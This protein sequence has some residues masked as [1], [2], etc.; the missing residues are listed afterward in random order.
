MT[1]S[2]NFGALFFFI[3]SILFIGHNARSETDVLDFIPA[4]IASANRPTANYQF[5][6]TPQGDAVVITLTGEDPLDGTLTFEVVSDPPNGDLTGTPPNLTYS[7]DT[8]FTGKDS[9]SFTVTNRMGTSKAA[10]VDIYVIDPANFLKN[11]MVD[12]AP[13][14]SQ[15]DHAGAFYFRPNYEKVF[16]EFG[17][18]VLEDHQGQ[19]KDNAAFEYLVDKNA[20]VVS[21]VN[22]TVAS[23]TYQDGSGDWEIHLVP[24]DI[25]DVWLSIDHIIDPTVAADDQVTAGQILGKPGTWD[26]YVGRVEIQIILTREGKSVC[27]F[28]FFDPATKSEY[29]SKVNQLIDDWETYKGNSQIYSE[30]DFQF[31][32]CRN[33]TT[34]M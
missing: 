32:G 16:L 3:I 6:T 23:V 9:F 29:E 21:P 25:N 4:I 12:F 22:A 17:Q 19:P 28:L 11:L 5:L 30:E 27:P 34:G 31:T 33:A 1:R 13:Y 24:V 10:S 14:D 20:D 26:F 7:P 15:N 18:D 8:E 2:I